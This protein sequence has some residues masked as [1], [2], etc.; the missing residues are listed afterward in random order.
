MR[1]L[2]TTRRGAG[3]FGPL[4]PFAQAFRR[5]GDELAST[6]DRDRALNRVAELV[7][8]DLADWC[9]IDVADDANELRRVAAARAELTKPQSGKVQQEPELEVRTVVESGRVRVL[10]AL[11]EDSSGKRVKFLGGL[12]ARSVICVPLWARKQPLGALTMARTQ[13]GPVYTADDV[14]LAEDIAGMRVVQAYTRE[15]ANE[16]FAVSMSRSTHISI[17]LSQRKAR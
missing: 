16:R 11:G 6:L 10:P 4:V 8:A 2:I 5:A 1:V 14:A 3:H 12:E 17:S 9:V 15:R 13:R 7:V